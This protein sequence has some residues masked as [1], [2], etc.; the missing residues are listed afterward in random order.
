M[1]L[2]WLR[3][4]SV[5]YATPTF[6]MF[7][8]LQAPYWK[9]SGRVFFALGVW[10]VAGIAVDIWMTSL[11]RQPHL[12]PQRDRINQILAWGPFLGFTLGICAWMLR[13]VIG[14]FLA[15]RSPPDLDTALTQVAVILPGL[16]FHYFELVKS[17]HADLFAYVGSFYVLF[18]VVWLSGYLLIYRAMMLRSA[19]EFAMAVAAKKNYGQ[20]PYGSAQRKL[21]SKALLI[22][23]AFDLCALLPFASDFLIRHSPRYPAFSEMLTNGSGFI[24][25]GV[26]PTGAYFALWLFHGARQFLSTLYRVDLAT[27]EESGHDQ[28]H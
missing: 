15:G 22:A 19:A 27:I 11:S 25:L 16:D 17:G 4:P 20:P 5:W 6:G 23:I 13:P 24:Y 26:I 7:I 18:V 9:Y 12:T 3:W 2:G 8:A 28:S 21:A 14:R 1:S 10:L